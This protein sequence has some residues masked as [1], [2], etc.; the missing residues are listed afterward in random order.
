MCMKD[1]VRRALWLPRGL[2]ILWRVPSVRAPAG[3]DT[4]WGELHLLWGELQFQR[5][6]DAPFAVPKPCS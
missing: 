4:R 1:F 3:P 5:H 2:R 6:R